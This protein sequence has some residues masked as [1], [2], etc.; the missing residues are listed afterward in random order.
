MNIPTL[1]KML[2]IQEQSQICGEFLDWLLSKY[3]MYDKK[4]KRESP[5]MEVM[6][7]CG[8]Y[9]NKDKLLAKFFDIDLDVVER[10]KEQLLQVEQN[11]HK[12]HHCKLC[13]SYIEED[14]LSVCNKCAY[15]YEF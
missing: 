11:K 3:T 2:E 4:M 13:G 15:E 14:N 5:F 9:I 1:N 12:P 7:D 10:E 6:R 8:D